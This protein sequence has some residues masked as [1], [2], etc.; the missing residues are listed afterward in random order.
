MFG[1]VCLLFAVR[2]LG[3]SILGSHGCREWCCVVRILG[4]LFVLSW[5]VC[6]ISYG[7]LC[8]MLE[9]AHREIVWVSHVEVH[10]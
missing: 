2:V 5:Y 6:G 4:E 10:E 7:C 3:I 8:T 1:C 9:R